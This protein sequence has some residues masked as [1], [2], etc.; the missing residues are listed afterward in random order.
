MLK[1]ICRPEGIVDGK[2]NGLCWC[3]T[4]ADERDCMDVDNYLEEARN[5]EWI[6]RGI[7]YIQKR[8]ETNESL[9]QA[10]FFQSHK[11]RDQ[12][13]GPGKERKMYVFFWRRR[14]VRGQA[15]V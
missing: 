12:H 2:F 11:G 9:S 3:S 10:S 7:T 4:V 15:D 14:S 1:T 5:D 8:W 6:D 13:G